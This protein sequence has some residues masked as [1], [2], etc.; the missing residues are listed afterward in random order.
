MHARTRKHTHTHT[1]L[2]ITVNTVTWGTRY[3]SSKGWLSKATIHSQ[4][5]HPASRTL[6]PTAAHLLEKNPFVR[7]DESEL[8]WVSGTAAGSQHM[9]QSFK[10]EGPSGWPSISPRLIIFSQTE[11]HLTLLW[12]GRSRFR[13]K[14]SSW[15]V[16]SSLKRERKLQTLTQKCSKIFQE[17]FPEALF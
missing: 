7:L 4:S 1:Y 10:C 14:S 6:S 15:C 2:G 12:R 11:N 13:Q 17:V 3:N 16:C 5:R 8:F 9:S